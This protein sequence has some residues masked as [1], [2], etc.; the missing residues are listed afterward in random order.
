MSSWSKEELRKIAGSR[1][2]DDQGRQPQGHLAEHTRFAITLAGTSA[3]IKPESNEE[4][5]SPQKIWPKGADVRR[6]KPSAAC[7][8]SS[9]HKREHRQAAG[10]SSQDTSNR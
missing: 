6:E 1:D 2:G 9:E 7:C 3:L 10:Q 4:N 8:S 5:G